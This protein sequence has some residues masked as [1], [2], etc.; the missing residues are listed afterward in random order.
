MNG[1]DQRYRTEIAEKDKIIESLLISREPN[2]EDP[3]YRP[4]P[5]PNPGKP[6]WPGYP[7]PPRL[8]NHRNLTNYLD[9]LGR[10]GRTG[11]F[12]DSGLNQEKLI[13]ALKIG[14]QVMKAQGKQE[15]IGPD[16]RNPVGNDLFIR[17]SDQRRIRDF[18]KYFGSKLA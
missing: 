15:T 13:E 12:K 9:N 7:N 2:E 1:W 6:P 10:S 18:D 14:V 4:A 16:P 17:P 5:I 8:A 11:S 3:P